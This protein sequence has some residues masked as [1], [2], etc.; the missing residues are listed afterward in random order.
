MKTDDIA[1]L[2]E[3][4][5]LVIAYAV[6]AGKLPDNTLPEAVSRLAK[7]TDTGEPDV[8]AFQTAMNS[9]VLAMEPMTIADLR[10]GR[11][12]FDSRNVK[13][14][15]RWQVGL[16]V[17]TLVI[18]G[19]IA[20]CHFLIQR[21]EVAL[22]AF[23]ES[24]DARGSEKIT[25]ARK[26]VQFQDALDPK[27][28]KFDE[29]QRA[30]H[31]LRTLADLTVVSWEALR[32]L[33]EESP[34]PLWDQVK[35]TAALAPVSVAHAAIP[36]TATPSAASVQT[37]DHICDPRERPDFVANGYPAWLKN[38][39]YDSVDE[40]CFASTL[41]LDVQ[42]LRLNL[43]EWVPTI[44][45]R[46]SLQ[47]AWVLPFLYGLLGACVYIMRRL[48]F[49]A[50]EAFVENVVIVLR[51]ALGALSGVVIS[52][53]AVPNSGTAMPLI[54]A[55]SWPFALAFLAGFSIDNLFFMLD[56]LNRSI[57]GRDRPREA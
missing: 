56:R 24:R 33:A 32:R 38:V 49:Y 7:L 45:Q 44:Q 3:D 9:A 8:L 4:A 47:T 14:R 6:R 29:Y 12:P 51:L 2:L 46:I 21:E 54:Q 27:S 37:I 13:S 28:C 1:S 16:A 40:I 10:A 31:D 34:W 17:F 53:F 18:V 36:R 23:N 48:L 42:E 52:W 30:R 43:A 35:K 5:R 22:R 39:I 15:K 20:H 26:I 11:S 50:K 57:S 41:K 55:S 25:A 19:A